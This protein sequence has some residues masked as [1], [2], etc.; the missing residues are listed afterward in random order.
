MVYLWKAVSALL[1]YF[2]KQQRKTP[3]FTKNANNLGSMHERKRLALQA[4]ECL[5]LIDAS[6]DIYFLFGRYFRS[7]GKRYFQI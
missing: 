3:T 2:R 1:A 5:N 7:F 6:W 4:G